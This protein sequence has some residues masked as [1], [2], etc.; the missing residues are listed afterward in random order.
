L[1]LRFRELRWPC[2]YPLSMHRGGGVSPV[3]V[4]N[5]SSHGARI[6]TAPGDQLARGDAVHL[7]L[8][9]GR[10]AA[11]VRWVRD[12]MAGLRFAQTMAP[13]DM[14]RIRGHQGGVPARPRWNLTLQELR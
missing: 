14:A 13:R 12:G 9:P 3:R 7:D 2:D 8:S 11:T 4:V 1:I 6:V 5:L 10:I